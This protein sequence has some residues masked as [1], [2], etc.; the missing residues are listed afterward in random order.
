METIT[1]G[2]KNAFRNNV[3]TVSIVLILAISIAMAL[4]M[5]LSLK[6]VQFKINDVKSSVGNY[7]TVSPAG[8]RGFEGGGNLLADADVATISSVSNVKKVVKSISDRMN[9]PAD[10][11]MVMIVRERRREIGVLKAI[12]ASNVLI[13]AQFAVESLILTLIS[14]IAG[15]IL[16]T[17]LSNPVLNVLVSN[18]ETSLQNSARN[19]GGPGG[20]FTRFAGGVGQGAGAALRNLHATVG[21]QIILYGLAAAVVIA[22][23]GSAIP[24]FI[25]SKVRS[26][27]VLRSE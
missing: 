10:T 13:V 9:N 7:I 20:A 18:S 8:I 25:I 12:G 5:L 22:I 16:G 14:A 17:F 15:T 6:T 1:R 19:A 21:W 24:A 27:E 26:A 23:L 3:R 2:V 11:N 4:I